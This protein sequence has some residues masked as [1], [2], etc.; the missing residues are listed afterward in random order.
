MYTTPSS[1]KSIHQV[2]PSSRVDG[3][4]GRI[5]HIR[6]R[7]IRPIQLFDACLEDDNFIDVSSIPY[8]D[9]DDDDAVLLDESLHSSLIFDFNASGEYDNNETSERTLLDLKVDDEDKHDSFSYQTPQI[10]P[11][12]SMQVDQ[13]PKRAMD[14]TIYFELSASSLTNIMLPEL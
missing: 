12:E 10:Y 3:G 6:P 2:N 9:M 4:V 7:I 5:A 1:S 13:K 8:F 14:T 11:Y